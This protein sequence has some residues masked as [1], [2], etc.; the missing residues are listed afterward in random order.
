M[1]SSAQSLAPSAWILTI[2]GQAPVEIWGLSTTE[3]LRRAAQ[4]A[5]IPIGNIGVGPADAAM[6]CPR[7]VVI[8]RSDYVFD[9][10]IVRGMVAA[11][12]TILKP[13]DGAAGA[14]G[15]V[16]AHVEARMIPTALRLLGEGGRNGAGDVSGLRFVGPG[17]VARAHSSKLRRVDPPYLLPARPERVHSIERKVFDAS[18]KG[19]TDFVTKWIWPA[20]ARWVTHWLARWGVRPNAVTSVSWVLVFVTGFLFWRGWF[21][22]GLLFGWIMTFLDTVDGKL[23]RVT[24]TSSKA[25]DIFDHGLDL[26]H[27]PFWYLAWSAGLASG[28]VW[29]PALLV[30][31]GGY[32]V[33][34]AIEGLFIAACKTDIHT[35]R[36]VDSHFRAVTARRNP[37]LVLLTAATV[38]GRPDLGLVAVATWTVISIAFHTVRLTQ[39]VFERIR[40]R[41]LVSWLS[42]LP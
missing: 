15:C 8:F 25:G 26:V 36:P 5:G 34:R 38:V 16:A 17:D 18:Y 11:Q 40:G 2:P 14:E 35:W 9:E 1:Q 32:I 28:T 30:T 7:S 13:T 33:G 6:T 20:P 4:A 31:L 12:N 27:P 37:N 10:R 24:L 3:R 41:A 22:L 42:G 29:S 21:G 39:A 19:V 23:A